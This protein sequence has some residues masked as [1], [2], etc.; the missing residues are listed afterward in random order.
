MVGNNAGAPIS[1]LFA[2]R[3]MTFEDIARALGST[4]EHAQ[5]LVLQKGWRQHADM[6]GR[7][8]ASVPEA[9]LEAW[10]ALSVS[11][12]NAPSDPG[13]REPVRRDEQVGC[14]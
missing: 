11:L 7:T 1:R 13:V 2:F 5:S 9:Y 6:R 14:G 8:R 10:A 4:P 12:N 3:Y